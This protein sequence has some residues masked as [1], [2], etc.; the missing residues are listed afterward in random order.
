ME[1]PMHLN[2]N[3]GL[4]DSSGMADSNIY[5]GMISSIILT[6]SRPD[7]LFNVCLCARFQSDSR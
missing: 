7:I 2:Y 4:D 3:L 5:R 1:T 6:A